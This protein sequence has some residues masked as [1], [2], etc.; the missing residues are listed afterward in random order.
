MEASFE[1]DED[2]NVD[3]QQKHGVSFE[4]A[5]AAFADPNV[6]ILSDA[7]HSTEEEARF[8]AA[9]TKL[10]FLALASG[11]NTDGVTSC[12]SDY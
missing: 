8:Y 9:L 3:N 10:E 11:V 4:Q 12:G 1:W 5:Q 6:L 7:H 2:K